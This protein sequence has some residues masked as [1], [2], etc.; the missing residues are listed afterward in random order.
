MKVRSGA[1]LLSFALLSTA[2]AAPRDAVKFAGLLEQMRGH[3]AAMLYNHQKGD[4]AMALKHSRHPANELYDAVKADL[5]PALQR[6]F[7]S[8][9]ARINAVLASHK[10]TAALNEALNTFTRDVEKA[11]TTVPA[12][13]RQ[14]PKYGARVISLILGNTKTEYGSGVKAGQVANL[15]EYQDAQFYL[16][17]AG[18]WLTQYKAR[19]P[20]D[21]GGQAAAALAQ[22]QTLHQSKADP[23]AFNVQLERARTEL[24]EIS[25]DPL[26]PTAGPATDFATIRELLTQARSHY[27]GGMH[28]AANEALISA[29]LD[30]FEQL[31]SPLGARNKALEHKLETALRDTLRALVN[32]KVSAAQFSAAVD[33]TLADLRTAQDLLR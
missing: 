6:A 24:A 8:D 2:S 11:L 5:S 33:R 7:R 32:Q 29:Y 18:R 30:H 23:K 19:F 17:G 12:A 3:Y 20:A 4:M 28:E 22:A 9:Y 1:L 26:T 27:A 31:E 25:G 14:D 21:Q 10:P 13:T 16:V 15:A